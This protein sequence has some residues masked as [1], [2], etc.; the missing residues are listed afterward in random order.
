VVRRLVQVA[1]ALVLVFAAAQLI[2]P[3]RASPPTDQSRTIQAQLDTASRLP[4]V[5]ER[6]CG[7]CHSNATAAWPWYAQIAPI[8]WLAASSVAEGRKAINF[9]DWAAYTPLQQQALLAASCR[10]VTQ[11]KMPPGVYTQL[12]PGTRLS[13]QDV[14]T[15]CAAARSHVTG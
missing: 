11:G 8:S 5:L 4:G 9:S 12:R 15:I 6:A 13:M 10:D 1:G 2:R 14:E 7:D 3:G